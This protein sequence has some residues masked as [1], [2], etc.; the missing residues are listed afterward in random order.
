[1]NQARFRGR[2]SING[3]IVIELAG[4]ILIPQSFLTRGIRPRQIKG[5]LTRG[6]L[7]FEC[8]DVGATRLHAGLLHTGVDLGQQL[9][10][11]DHVADF[12]MEFL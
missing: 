4:R 5:C 12:H 10:C 1:M 9:P 11:F 7:S 8:F 3:V 2:Q 6:D